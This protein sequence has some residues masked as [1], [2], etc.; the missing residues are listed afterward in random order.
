VVR[1]LPEPPGPA[2][3][4]L[5]VVDGTGMPAPG[6]SVVESVQAEVDRVVDLVIDHALTRPDE[7]LAAIALNT[8]HADRVREA[9]MSVAAGSAS[10][11]SFF[12]SD[13]PE[14]FTVVDV[15]SP[16][17]LRWAAIGLTLGFGKAPRG[18]V[19]YRFGVI[20][21]PDG[22]ECLVDALDAVRT[23]LTVVSC[24][25]PDDLD[26]DRLRYAGS[27][28]LHCLLHLAAESKSE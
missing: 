2:R 21:G 1:P 18:R 23:R 22:D 13:R 10:V 28:M 27:Q 12:D 17:G 20:S 7:T 14:A 16:A 19:L 15:E 8:R 25:Y 4:G 5:D 24:R 3:I 9:V 26:P 6:V 11:A